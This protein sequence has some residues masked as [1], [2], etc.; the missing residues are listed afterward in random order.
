MTAFDFYYSTVMDI[1]A[2]IIS[3]SFYD[4]N[5]TRIDNMITIAFE[6]GKDEECAASRVVN[7]YEWNTIDH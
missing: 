4:E 1:A 6:E 7:F 2:R 3:E 5:T